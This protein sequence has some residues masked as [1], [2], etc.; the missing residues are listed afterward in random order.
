MKQTEERT[1]Y[2]SCTASLPSRA[3]WE[4]ESFTLVSLCD[5]LPRFA[6]QRTMTYVEYCEPSVDYPTYWTPTHAANIF[7]LRYCFSCV[8]EAFE[9]APHELSSG[10]AT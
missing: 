3:Y 6:A 7:T 2:V 1:V 9:E 5:A 8:A 10:P 4:S